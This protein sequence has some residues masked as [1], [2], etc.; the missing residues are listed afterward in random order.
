MAKRTKDVLRPADLRRIAERHPDI[1]QDGFP[2]LDYL[3]DVEDAAD[4]HPERTD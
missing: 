3:T 1:P 2:E 4:E